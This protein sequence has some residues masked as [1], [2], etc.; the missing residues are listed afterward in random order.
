MTPDARPHHS[1]AA[2]SASVNDPNQMAAIPANALRHH[3]TMRFHGNSNRLD[4]QWGDVADDPVAWRELL[5][6]W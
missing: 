4:T 5:T 6:K 1:M 3:F 2:S